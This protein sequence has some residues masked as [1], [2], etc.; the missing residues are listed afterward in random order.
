LKEKL[1]QHIDAIDDEMALQM[2]HDAAVEYKLF[3]QKDTL[4]QLTA[5]QLEKLRESLQQL[6]DGKMENE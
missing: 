4:D 1:H 6:N 5:K 2:L 3:G